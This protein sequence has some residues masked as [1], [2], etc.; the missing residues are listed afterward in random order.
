[1]C[2]SKVCVNQGGANW[3]F[4]INEVNLLFYIIKRNP[5]HKTGEKLRS[6]AQYFREIKTK[7]LTLP[8]VSSLSTI[9]IFDNIMNTLWRFCWK[10][11]SLDFKCLPFLDFLCHLK[12][13]VTQHVSKSVKSFMYIYYLIFLKNKSEF[14]LELYPEFDMNV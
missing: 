12:H 14:L 7:T 1:M 2:L 9:Q 3:F 11:I 6:Q 10:Y 8:E 13:C 5:P 4:K